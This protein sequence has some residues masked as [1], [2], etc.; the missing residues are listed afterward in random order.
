MAAAVLETDTNVLARDTGQMRSTLRRI[1]EELEGMYG[2]VRA[3]DAMWDGPAN[4]MFKLQFR[5]DYENMMS[6]CETVRDLIRCMENA[7][8]RYRIGGAQVESAVEQI[9]I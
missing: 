5:N 6:I 8:Q 9:P 2:A 1:L 4:E 3:L 7:A